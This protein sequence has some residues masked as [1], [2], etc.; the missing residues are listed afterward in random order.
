MSTES[1]FDAYADTYQQEL[2]GAL[3]TT[4]ET[5]EYYAHGRI[6]HLAQCL[7]ERHATAH[8]ILDYG[9]G[10]GASTAALLQLPGAATITGVDASPEFIAKAS[11]KQGA[12]NTRFASLNEF[13]PQAHFDVVY[14]NGVFHHIAPA[15]RAAV[16]QLI[17]DSLRP[18]G[19]FSLWEN[20]PWNP[21]T[22]YVMSRC[23]FDRDAVT[24]SAR[25]GRSLLRC[26]GFEV[27]Q[28]DFLFFF[29]R[30]L[31]VL[32]PLERALR[33]MPLGGQYQILGRKPRLADI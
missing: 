3:A 20:N 5:R 2:N 18:G 16:L 12:H 11:Q 7:L 25:A 27:L 1:C 17:F 31:A 24:I 4:G 29:P 10:D 9:C 19:L 26:A 33:T 8:D 13:V 30:S 21:G 23:A 32:R 15:R 28:T 14:C 22:R 6:T